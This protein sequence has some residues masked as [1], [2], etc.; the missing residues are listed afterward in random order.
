MTGLTAVATAGLVLVAACG[1][2]GGGNASSTAGS[3]A[4]DGGSD[5]ALADYQ[6]NGITIGYANEEPYDYQDA[7]GNV[8]GMAPSVGQ[9]IL[10]NLDITDVTWTKVDFRGL[11]PGLKAGRFDM[12]M[13][14]ASITP[15]RA[16]AVDYSD[17]VYCV[18][19][20]MAV[21]KGNPLNLSD[22]KSVADNPDAKLAVES[23]TTE[24]KYA[25]AV[26]VAKDQLVVVNNNSALVASV[27][28]G[29][30]DA[31]ALT[32][33]TVRSLVKKS[34]D[35]KLVAL[36]GFNPVIDGE[37]KLSCGAPQFKKGSDALLTAYNKQLDKLQK[38]GKVY[39]VV[40]EASPN[41]DAFG[42]AKSQFE[43]A[44]KHT[45]EDFANAG[46]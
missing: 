41:G 37:E 39:S 24:Q 28:T 29:R 23:G 30:A 43:E 21:K 45:F 3:T 26:G 4:G 9:E 12:T 36:D 7:Q 20:A 44:K 1:S 46:S 25:T 27:K 14:A 16:Q 6:D 8:T 5:S 2:S 34:G 22:F 38:A 33:I 15:E 13:A 35:G 32:G 42:F 18:M 17:P 19:E 10:S 31:F 40:K 11:I